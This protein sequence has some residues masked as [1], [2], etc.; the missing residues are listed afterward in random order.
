MLVLNTDHKSVQKIVLSKEQNNTKN[1]TKQLLIFKETKKAC[2]HYT[3]Y[4]MY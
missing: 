2:N 1:Y 3:K 4:K